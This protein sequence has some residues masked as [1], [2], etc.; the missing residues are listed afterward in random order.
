M[1][2][3]LIVDDNPAD[4]F[5]WE[6][7]I[8]TARPELKILKAHDGVEALE[9][10]REHGEDIDIILLDINMP[11][12]NG[13]EF[14]QAYSE[15]Y[16]REIPVVVMLTSSNFDIDKERTL[17]YK[18]VKDYIVKPFKGEYINQLENIFSEVK[19]RV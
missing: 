13:P 6:A 4:L 3:V 16:D 10:L 12:M 8:S 19:S 5:L 2:S 18:C 17:S 11:R 1:K 14:L 9:V 7:I 15:E